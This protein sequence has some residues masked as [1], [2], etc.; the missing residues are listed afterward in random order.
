[1]LIISNSGASKG[2]LFYAFP[3]SWVVLPSVAAGRAGPRE[4]F[5]LGEGRAEHPHLGPAIQVNSSIPSVRSVSSDVALDLGPK[6]QASPAGFN[7]PKEEVPVS[8]S[9]MTQGLLIVENA[10]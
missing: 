9:S 4:R 6:P 10:G 2:A 7:P 1:M 3:F 5:E 8:H